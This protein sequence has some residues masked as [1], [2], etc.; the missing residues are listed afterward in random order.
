MPN[1]RRPV[2][3]AIGTLARVTLT[4]LRAV[5]TALDP[6]RL[7][8]HTVP[9]RYDLELEPDLAAATFSGRVE[10]DGRRPAEPTDALV[11]NA[12]ELEIVDVAVDGEPA[13]WRLDETTERLFVTPDGG[14][15]PGEHRLTIEFTGIL[16]DRL[17]GFY[18]STL[19][20]R[21]RRRAA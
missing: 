15:A 4:E 11:L 10:I 16:N 19:P 13:A 7:P 5:P 8:R 18:R 2:T 12:A 3:V 21:R 9:T 20:R 6:Y 1:G 17:R 14:V